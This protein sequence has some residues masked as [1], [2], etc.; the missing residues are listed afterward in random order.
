MS[1]LLRQ[2]ILDRRKQHS[3]GWTRFAG[4]EETATGWCRCAGV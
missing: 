4:G 2:R 3:T 1:E